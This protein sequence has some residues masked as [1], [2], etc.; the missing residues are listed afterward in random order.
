[1]VTVS[2]SD[3]DPDA[4]SLALEPLNGP[5]ADAIKPKRP[6]LSPRVQLGLETLRL[7]VQNHGD[8]VTSNHIPPHAR[9]VS[10]ETWRSYFYPAFSADSQ[11]AKRVAFQYVRNQLQDRGIAAVRNENWWIAKD[12]GDGP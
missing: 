5:V 11:N 9:C 8:T 6:S 7:A 2:L 3:I 4:A 12:H 10:T 1:M